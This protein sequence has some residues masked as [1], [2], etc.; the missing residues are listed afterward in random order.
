MERKTWKGIVGEA[1]GIPGTCT[2]LNKKRFFPMNEQQKKEEAHNKIMGQLL[3]KLGD[4]ES[5]AKKPQRSGT[6]GS[7]AT[8]TQF[9]SNSDTY[10]AKTGSNKSGKGYNEVMHFHPIKEN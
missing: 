7:N 5:I 6:S 10:S 4:Y 8:S 9:S 2:L 3:S 1:T